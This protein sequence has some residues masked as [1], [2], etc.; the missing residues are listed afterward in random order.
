MRQCSMLLVR[1]IERGE[2]LAMGSTMV[3]PRFRGQLLE[4][5]LHI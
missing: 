1:N 3:E 4:S 2:V 5:Y